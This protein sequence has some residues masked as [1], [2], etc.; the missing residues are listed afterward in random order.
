[1]A[2]ATDNLDIQAKR[3]YK[4]VQSNKIIQE[5]T[6]YFTL[7]EKKLLLIAISMIQENDDIEKRYVIKYLDVIEILGI[8]KSGEVYKNLKTA[9]KKLADKSVWF[10]DVEQEKTKLI[11][12]LANIELD[13]SGSVSFNFDTSV[14]QYLFDLK[15]YFT[16]FELWNVLLLK[17][18]SSVDF[19]EYIKS[20]SNLQGFY[21]S[22]EDLMDKFNV[23]YR[24]KKTGE[25]LKEN[26]WYDEVNDLVVSKKYKNYS[27]FK[28]YIL[29]KA[30]EEINT[31]T[32]LFFEYKEEKK[33][34]KIT[35]LQFKIKTLRED[36]FVLRKN[37]VE[38]ALFL[39][40][41][42]PIQTNLDLWK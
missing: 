5:T 16:Q 38:N 11:R 17:S 4:I 8:S 28:R 13:K 42:Q 10:F 1:M 15:A 24:D 39:N 41:D 33:G 6:N 32:D 35:G 29:N 30:Q 2:K 7:N 36:D 3:N 22:V 27:D 12:W 19:Y 26:E 20:Y 21:V 14:K 18:K 23:N 37:A 9:I 25:K 40:L 31:K 34:R